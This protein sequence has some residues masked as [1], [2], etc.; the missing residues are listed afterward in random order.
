MLHCLPSD[1][2]DVPAMELM[3][4]VS[5]YNIRER[6]RKDDTA[7][8]AIEQAARDYANEPQ[9]DGRVIPGSMHR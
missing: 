3:E 7:L 5:F 2:D 8:A 9:L 6:E 4:I 1:L